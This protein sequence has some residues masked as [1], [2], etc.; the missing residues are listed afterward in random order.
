VT[1]YGSA[2]TFGAAADS[3]MLISNRFTARSVAPV[4][5]EP[6]AHRGDRS[7]GPRALVGARLRTPQAAGG[8]FSLTC[9]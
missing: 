5:S 8:W 1:V 3:V 2:G 7:T 9:V 4:R 6:V